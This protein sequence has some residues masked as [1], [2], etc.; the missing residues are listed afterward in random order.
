MCHLFETRV[1]GTRS[2][3]MR[4]QYIL[5]ILDIGPTSLRNY[6]NYKI[7]KIVR[8]DRNY[9]D[10]SEGLLIEIFLSKFYKNS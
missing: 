1:L 9:F 2:H 4:L 8:F 6:E 10:K 5:R 7:S 3:E